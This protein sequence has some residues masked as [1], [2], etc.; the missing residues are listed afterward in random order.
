MWLFSF[1]RF[2]PSGTPTSRLPPD[3]PLLDRSRGPPGPGTLT[4]LPNADWLSCQ[5]SFTTYD[6]FLL[7]GQRGQIQGH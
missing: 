4:E 2:H 1:A 5:A 6:C 3:V 7:V